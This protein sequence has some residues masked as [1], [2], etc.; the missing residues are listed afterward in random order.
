MNEAS[1]ELLDVIN[2]R[3]MKHLGARAGSSSSGSTA[4]PAG[5]APNRY[6]MAQ[7]KDAAVNIDYHVGV[8]HNFYS[9]LI[10]SAA[11]GSTRGRRRSSSRSSP[12][13]PHRLPRP[14]SW[15]GRYSNR[16][17]AQ[18]ASHRAHLEWT[19]SRLIRWAETT[20]PP[21][22]TSS[23]RSSRAPS[24]RQGYRSCMG[25]N[26][27]ER[28]YGP[29]LWKQPACARS[30]LGPSATRPSRLLGPGSTPCPSTNHPS[31]TQLPV[32][33]NIRGAGYYYKEEPC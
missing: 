20:A 16:E 3:P 5:L 21:R 26:A 27:S 25:I 17:G 29:T 15:P 33:D 12:L 22:A 18:P 4:G 6:E 1:W 11:S 30:G 8:D 19:P 24:S 2:N 13:P 28:R 31:A 14:G 32:H 9:V 23:P 7:W 10:S